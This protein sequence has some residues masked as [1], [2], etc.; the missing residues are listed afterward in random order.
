MKIRV[1]YTPGLI[2]A[3]ARYFASLALVGGASAS[4]AR[5]VA[6]SAMTDHPQQI[7]ELH[8]PM[9]RVDTG[10][11]TQAR[12]AE[13]PTFDSKLTVL[14]LRQPETPPAR[15]AVLLDR[16]ERQLLKVTA[17]KRLVQVTCKTTKC[18][19][20]LQMAASAKSANKIALGKKRARAPDNFL[21]FPFQTLSRERFAETT[22][23]ITERGLRWRG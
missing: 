13:R 4:L 20:A 9:S 22:A 2:L 5:S 1:G 18:R 15:M 23:D 11:R 16:S 12:I 6:I 21:D 19:N 8:K 10:L 3:Y 14:A 7:A 17:K